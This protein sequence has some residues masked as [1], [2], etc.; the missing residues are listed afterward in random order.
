MC[1]PQGHTLKRRK[2]EDSGYECDVCSAD[3]VEGKRF[4][5]CRTCDYCMCQ[6]CHGN[7]NLTL[8]E[9]Q[10]LTAMTVVNDAGGNL[11]LPVMGRPGR[12]S[13]VLALVDKVSNCAYDDI[14][15]Y[16][17]DYMLNL[18]LPEWIALKKRVGRGGDS[19]IKSYGE[20]Y[21]TRLGGRHR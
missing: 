10:A 20:W 5:D 9:S 3:I 11:E 16:E 14:T 12:R 2:A 6:K 1:C 18:T 8:P 17:M 21:R 19:E 15:A 4:Y 7:D 13:A